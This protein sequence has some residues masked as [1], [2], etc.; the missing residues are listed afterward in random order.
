MNCKNCG[1]L[2]IAESDFCHGCGG[3][4]IRNRLTIRNLLAHVGEQ[5]FNV[6]NTFFKT[7]SH[8]ITK[9][10][11]VIGGYIAGVRKRYINPISY[12]AIALT[13]AGIQIFI[14]RKFFP[15]AMDLSAMA[16]KG[17]EEF[18]N[19]WFKLV[20]EYQSIFVMFY[21]PIY[22]IISRLVFIDKKKYNYT[23]HLV[24]FLYYTGQLSI[25]MFI[26]V[27]ILF[28]LG[29][30]YGS[31]SPFAIVLQIFFAAFYLKRMYVLSFA[32]IALRTFI[33]LMLMMAV[34]I[35]FAVLGVLLAVVG[36][37]TPEEIQQLPNRMVN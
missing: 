19:N 29:S 21:I 25:M 17:Q 12:F 20:Q 35:G 27:M 11:E 3:K 22:A 34:F 6:D 24:I 7:F 14:V 28:A 9:P 23:E 13:L 26:P 1:D 16:M 18:Q 30:D 31:I 4:I 33:F 36:G 32:G 37:L 8:L 10:E 15:E 2:L 5:F